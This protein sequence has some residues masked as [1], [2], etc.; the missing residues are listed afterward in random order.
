MVAPLQDQ[1]VEKR[2]EK[3]HSDHFT[4]PFS[5]ST[6]WQD[7][8]PTTERRD[9]QTNAALKLLLSANMSDNQ[10]KFAQGTQTVI[11]H[12]SANYIAFSF[13]WD[14]QVEFVKM[15]SNDQLTGLLAKT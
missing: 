11:S 2:T 6:L 9:Q 5:T 8:Q 1:T 12:D 10:K 15:L 4:T 7:L 3:I 13:G 14:K